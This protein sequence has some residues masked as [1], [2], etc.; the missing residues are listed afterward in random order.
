MGQSIGFEQIKGLGAARIQKLNKAGILRP[1]DLLLRF[2]KSYIDFN[3]PFDPASCTD[4]SDVTV[5]GTVANEPKVQYL[6]K[7]LCIVKAVLETE[8]GKIDA[9]WFNQRFIAR[10]LPHGKR[11]CV[12]GKVKKFHNKISIT[13]PVLLPNIAD[14]ILP[15]YRAVPGVPSNVLREA[16]DVLLQRV[17]VQSFFSDELRAKFGLQPLSEAI[18]IIHRPQSLPQV[19]QAARSLALEKLGYSLSVFS[20]VKKRSANGPKHS[21]AAGDAQM[22]AAIEN[23]P[24]ILTDGQ[25][26]ALQDILSAMRAKPVMNRLLQGDVGCGKTIVALLAMYFAHLN[27]HQSVLMAPT[28]ILAMQHYRT[29]INFLEPLGVKTAL[30]SGALPKNQRD[31]T[32]FN[33]KTHAVDV[34]VG[35]H[36]LLSPDV[37]FADL[38]LIITDEQQRFGVN[39][40]SALENKATAP[41][42]LV[43][44]ATPIPRTLALCMY[45][46]LEQSDIHT[47]P[48]N[49]PHITTK[50]VPE[51]KHAAM[52]DYIMARATTEQ[53]Y[54]VCPRIDEDD[55]LTAAVS[56]FERL[57]ADYPN[58]KCGLLHGRMRESEKNAVMEAFA[59]GK[60][61]VLVS[62]TVVE[63]G[64][65]VP[66]AVNMIIFNAERYGLSQLHQLRGRVGRGTQDGYCFLPIAGE[67][68]D[69]LRFFCDT[70]DGFAL[71]EYDF[72]VRGAGDFIG[73]RQ[74]GE[75]DDLPVKIDADL[76]RT[77]KAF[78]EAAL[79]DEK[80]R[81]R[82]LKSCTDTA[83][84]YI[85][86]ITLN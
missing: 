84:E 64:I 24:F 16:I 60:I 25:R 17:Q 6:K 50:L 5:L 46:E 47:M 56:T 74:H 85:R 62:T 34:I 44:T 54:V 86:S 39:Q 23:L 29:A 28:E 12:T 73:T 3:A 11:V 51:H 22:R 13:A 61:R 18:R 8:H 2:P 76:I 45:G 1:L 65:D 82:L 31:E 78:S 38:S 27:G 26:T 30:L 33:I 63:V 59:C 79:K 72:G 20:L 81:I 14:G 4:G 77:A 48:K 15:L 42:C 49:R 52:F 53:S 10:A 21:Y 66:T 58:V 7:G 69:R 67:A 32:L 37:T 80:T 19:A 55:D 83:E 43:M 35:T 40:R 71:S 36:A 9:A 70:T 41:D 57:Q 75:A 68:P